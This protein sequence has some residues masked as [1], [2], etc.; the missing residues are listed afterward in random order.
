MTDYDYAID[1]R[2]GREIKMYCN[3]LRFLDSASREEIVGAV[4][5]FVKRLYEMTDF[6]EGLGTE[7][8]QRG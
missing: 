4:S 6:L 3:I 7:N 1:E 5:D 2:D 8:E